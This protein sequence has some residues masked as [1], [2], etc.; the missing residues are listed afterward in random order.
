M[1]LNGETTLLRQGESTFVRSGIRHRIRN[2]GVIPLE[3][4]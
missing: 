2:P 3:I 1:E 4:I